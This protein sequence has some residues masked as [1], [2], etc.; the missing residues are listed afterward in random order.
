MIS[1]LRLATFA[2]SVSLLAGCSAGPN[3]PGPSPDPNDP[4]PDP[5]NPPSC[6]VGPLPMNGDTATVSEDGTVTFNPIGVGTTATFAMAVKESADTD[7]TIIAA[8]STNGAFKVLS[9][10]PIYVPRGATVSVQVSFTPTTVGDTSADLVLS[11]AKMGNSHVAVK[12]AGLP[13]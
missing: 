2:L 5:N 6:G 3:G 1:T 9:P 8:S 4:N 13:D 10:V 12:G 11:T 7:E